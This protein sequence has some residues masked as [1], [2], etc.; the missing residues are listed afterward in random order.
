MKAPA[1]GV[2]LLASLPAAALA[3]SEADYV[4]RWC[5]GRGQ[6]EYVLDD[7]T[8]V[9][10]LTPEF[11]V[12]ADFGHK[13]AEAIGQALYYGHMTNRQPGVLL[14]VGPGDHRFLRRFHTAADGLGIRLFTLDKE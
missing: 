1:W 12:E 13:W 11:A 10:C 3:L 9:D 6:V 8:R 5:E 4:A 7:R 14:I 2:A